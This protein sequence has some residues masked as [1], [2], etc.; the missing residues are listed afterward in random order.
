MG[1]QTSFVYKLI[2]KFKSL[3]NLKYFTVT[4]NVFIHGF[5][6]IEVSSYEGNNSKLFVNNYKSNY[7]KYHEYIID[8]P[9]QTFAQF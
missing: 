7:T 6:T 8:K 3:D 1:K 9:Q 4:K 2:F 5:I